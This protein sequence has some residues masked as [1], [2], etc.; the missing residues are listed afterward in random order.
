MMAKAKAGHLRKNSQFSLY[1]CGYA[2]ADG[3][4]KD[5]DVWF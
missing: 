2:S 1:G 3:K 5:G 4:S